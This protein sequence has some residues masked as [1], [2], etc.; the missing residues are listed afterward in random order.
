MRKILASNVRIGDF[1]AKS[2]VN[3]YVNGYVHGI[4]ESVIHLNVH[5]AELTLRQ[6]PDGTRVTWTVCIGDGTT[7]VT[8]DKVYV[9]R[10]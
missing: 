5:F 3:G 10:G 4:V 1:V 9:E 7:K 6:G 8:S 2:V